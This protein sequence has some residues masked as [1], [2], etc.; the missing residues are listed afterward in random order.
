MTER[1]VSSDIGEVERRRIWTEELKLDLL[2]TVLVIWNDWVIYLK[3][4]RRSVSH[5]Q[6]SYAFQTVMDSLKQ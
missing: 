3:S 4:G 6:T 5:W 2:L 1:E